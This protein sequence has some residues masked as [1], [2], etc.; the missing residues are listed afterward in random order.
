[1][2]SIL[3]QRPWH[4]FDNNF[5]IMFK[6]GMGGTPPI[7]EKLSE[8]GQDFLSLCFVHDS[9]ERASASVLID[10]AFVKVWQYKM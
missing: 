1:M 2:N 4:E 7:P 10:H 6:V 8:E 9:V 5:Q 3:L